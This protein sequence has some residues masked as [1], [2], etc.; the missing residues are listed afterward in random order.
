MST[1][2][3]ALPLAILAGGLATRLRPITE[4]IPKALVPVAGEPFLTHQLRL[5]SR[6]GLRDIVLCVGHLGEQ[7]E[8][9]YGDGQAHGV[10]LRYSY[11]GPR[12]RGTAGALQRALPLL[13]DAFLVLYGDSYLEI[14]YGAVIER[15][16]ESAAPALMTVIE[17][18]HGTEPSNVWFENQTIR[19]YNKKQPLP[20]MRYIDYGLSAYRAECLADHPEG[21]LSNLQGALAEGG[22]MAGFEVTIPY[23]EIGS[24][25]GLKALED[26][27]HQKESGL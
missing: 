15:F 25:I 10:R 9:A 26:Y 11:D 22:Q 1:R 17:N 6:H 19:A 16:R 18:S 21:D 20:Q 7:I 23:H 5:L 24:P 13:G 12:L 2:T 8:A 14:D 3:E 27:F 4:T